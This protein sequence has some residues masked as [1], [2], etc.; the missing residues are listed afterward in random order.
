MESC[1]ATLAEAGV[2]SD[3]GRTGNRMLYSFKQA[4]RYIVGDF[5]CSY[6]MGGIEGT[7]ATAEKQHTLSGAIV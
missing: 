2:H 3:I 5:T 7:L 1:G 4:D 6:C